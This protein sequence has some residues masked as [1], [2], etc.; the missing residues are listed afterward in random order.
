M[1]YLKVNWG[2]LVRL[3]A[4]LFV[5]VLQQELNLWMNRFVHVTVQILRICDPDDQ[6]AGNQIK[7]I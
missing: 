2:A 7:H 6:L 3:E 1:Q 4:L 5:Q